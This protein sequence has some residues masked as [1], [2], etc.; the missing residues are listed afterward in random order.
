MPQSAMPYRLQIDESLFDGAM[1]LVRDDER[2]S[3][4]REEM[5]DLLSELADAVV[6]EPESSLDI[7]SKTALIY[8]SGLCL[9]ALSLVQG[10]DAAG[11]NPDGRFGTAVT[12]L[13]SS[14]YESTNVV[15]SLL[16]QGHYHQAI[17]LI[18]NILELCSTLLG[19]SLDK[20][21]REKYLAN[22]GLSLKKGEWNKYF[23]FRAVERILA[24][25]ESK[26]E[27]TDRLGLG[28]RRAELYSRYSS[29]AHNSYIEVTGSHYLPKR[30]FA[31]SDEPVDFCPF[32]SHRATF[33]RARAD[34]LCGVLFYAT[35]IFRLAVSDEGVDGISK[36]MFSFDGYRLWNAAVSLLFFAD[37]CYLCNRAIEDM[38]RMGSGRRGE[39][40]S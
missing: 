24:Q 10:R 28:E 36:E 13:L 34:E 32:G 8:A 15:V 25:Y 35:R 18:R 19:I 12:S 9:A 6:D 30:S 3:L 38:A 2:P 5:N 1:R 33:S 37:G 22:N 23:S 7:P 20:T 40:D 16:Q 4:S 17:V 27:G 29:F 26:I 14:I 31:Y 21:C 39:R 11:G